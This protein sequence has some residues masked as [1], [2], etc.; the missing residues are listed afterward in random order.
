M[1][2]STICQL[3]RPGGDGVRAIACLL[4]SLR[5]LS[6]L[7]GRLERWWSG[8][9]QNPQSS[10]FRQRPRVAKVHGLQS[11]AQWAIHHRGS[12]QRSWAAT[13]R[14][15]V[16][17]RAF[18]RLIKFETWSCQLI[19]MSMGSFASSC[20]N[21]PVKCSITSISG[22][23]HCWKSPLEQSCGSWCMMV[24]S[25][26]HAWSIP[27]NRANPRK[28]V[29][30][31]NTKSSAK[32]SRTWCGLRCSNLAQATMLSR[33]WLCRMEAVTKWSGSTWPPKIR[34]M[35]GSNVISFMIKYR[36]SPQ[37]TATLSS[38][39]TDGADSCVTAGWSSGG[40][41][42]MKQE[43]PIGPATG[44]SISGL[45]ARISRTLWKKRDG[46]GT[47]GREEGFAH[48]SCSTLS[49]FFHSASATKAS[50]QPMSIAVKPC[51]MTK[52]RFPSLGFH[53]SF[54]IAIALVLTKGANRWG[55]RRLWGKPQGS[56]KT[57]SSADIRFLCS[58][59]CTDKARHSSA[60]HASAHRHVHL[61]QPAARQVKVV[62]VLKWFWWL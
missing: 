10:P 4:R 21:L 14:P 5:C 34:D 9:W 59:L 38:S 40:S 61:I 37:K 7:L 62:T 45:V 19:C 1:K 11:W 44:I 18:G 29:S 41:L 46:I 22:P 60:E 20:S 17:K 43:W 52:Y 2:K 58:L 49:I 42:E 27:R 32:K 6:F 3:E 54:M 56:V 24:G 36:G 30:G 53:V 25:T 16:D 35:N 31:S 57:C 50:K 13:S 47:C 33:S 51:G 8:A 55:P 48:C 15:R 39:P 26:S 28:A 23:L 12:S